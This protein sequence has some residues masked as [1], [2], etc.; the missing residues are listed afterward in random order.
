MASNPHRPSHHLRRRHRL[1][2]DRPGDGG[3]GRAGGRRA[4]RWTRCGS[5]CRCCTA[6]RSTRLPRCW[7]RATSKR[8]GR[9]AR[10]RAVQLAEVGEVRFRHWGVNQRGET[11]FEGERRV[12]LKR[13]RFG[14]R[15]TRVG[16]AGR[17]RAPAR[18]AARQ[19]PP[20]GAQCA[21]APRRQEGRRAPAPAKA[22]RR[23][24]GRRR[25][26]GMWRGNSRAASRGRVTARR[27]SS[28]SGR[29]GRDG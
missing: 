26:A 3:Y 2:G 7:R 1:A 22:G 10:P 14:T 20:R 5:A 24:A 18:L 23:Q 12:L 27:N 11:V 25:S 6:T 21:P 8:R 29:D 17:S 9:A 28:A 19:K 16:E 15:A 13:A 4:R